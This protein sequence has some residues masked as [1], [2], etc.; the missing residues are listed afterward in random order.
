MKRVDEVSLHFKLQPITLEVVSVHTDYKPNVVREWD[1]A[2]MYRTVFIV[3]VWLTH[4]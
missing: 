4:S 3:L 2:S 1:F